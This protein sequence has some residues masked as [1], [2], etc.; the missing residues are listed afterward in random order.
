MVGDSVK[1]IECARNAGVQRA[2]LVRTGN[3]GEAER[4]F[5]SRHL[6]P[7]FVAD[8]LREAAFWI[9]QCGGAAPAVLKA[10]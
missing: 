3:G 7:D 10:P 8:D 2:V 5:S 9:T 4:A 6:R 1:D